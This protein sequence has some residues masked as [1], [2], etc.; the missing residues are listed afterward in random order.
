MRAQEMS[1]AP[2]S[3]LVLCFRYWRRLLRKSPQHSLNSFLSHPRRIVA[4]IDRLINPYG[5][6]SY[7]AAHIQFN[8]EL[9]RS[10]LNYTCFCNESTNAQDHFFQQPQTQI[11]YGCGLKHTINEYGVHVTRS[12]Q[13]NREALLACTPSVVD[14]RSC[15]ILQLDTQF[16]YTS[17]ITHIQVCI[18]IL[19]IWR[20]Q[21]D[22]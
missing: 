18:K 19:C 12:W 9:S 5:T 16:F 6:C 4:D 20:S 22:L 11:I 3:T 7:K 13:V 15:R 2:K 10:V 8:P 14:Y 1:W 17:N 21:N